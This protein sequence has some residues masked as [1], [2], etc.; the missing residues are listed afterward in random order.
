MYCP[1]CGHKLTQQ[2]TTHK[3]DFEE[4]N[5]QWAAR[6]YEG[7]PPE[8]NHSEDWA[9]HN[10]ECALSHPCTFTKHHPYQGTSAKPG[11][12]WSLSWIN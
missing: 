12:S 4:A 3:A 10:D 6:D 1:R 5:E 9:C 2:P 11:D 8:Q 7:E